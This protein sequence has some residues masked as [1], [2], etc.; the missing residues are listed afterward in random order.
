MTKLTKKN[1]TTNFIQIIVIFI[2]I[3]LLTSLFG[4]QESLTGVALITALLMFINIPLQLSPKK[5]SLMVSTSFL[6]YGTIATL[7]LIVPFYLMIPINL[8][9]IYTLMCAYS[10]NFKYKIFMP[11]ILLYI[12]DSTTDMNNFNLKNRFL[13]LLLTSVL[14]GIVYFIKNKNDANNVQSP[15]VKLESH[16][17]SILMS[18]GISLSLI[19]INCFHLSKGMWICMTVMSLTQISVNTTKQRLLRRIMGTITG[20]LIYFVIFSILIPVQYHL[21]LILIL[22]FV[23]SFIKNYFVQIIFITFNVMYSTENLF[24]LNQAILQR[25]SFI[26]LGCLIVTVITYLIKN[27]FAYQYKKYSLSK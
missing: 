1:I 24:S 23:F 27:I 10:N 25:I 17:V 5:A 11:F 15:H 14:L 26:I 8:I 3:N 16:Y 4:M 22:A 18:V 2:Y 20:I 21:Y 6:L 7:N 12:F 9:S 13:C 19:I